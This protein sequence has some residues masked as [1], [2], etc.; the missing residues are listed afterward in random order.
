[1]LRTHFMQQWLTLSDPAMEEAFFDTPLYREFAQ[2][3]EFTSPVQRGM[4]LN[5]ARI[6]TQK[7]A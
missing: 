2:L 5:G 1:M 7:W 3:D 4:S 6:S